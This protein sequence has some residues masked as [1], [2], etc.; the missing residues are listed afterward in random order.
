MS[1]TISFNPFG[2]QTPVGTFLNPTQGYVQGLA[3]DD[4]SSRLWLEGGTLDTG[5]TLTMWGG[6]PL[7]IEINQLTTGSEGL[8]PAVKRST[9][10]ANTLGWSVFN[11]AS[12]MVITPGNSVPQASVGNYIS[13]YR[14]GTNARI[15]A[16][17]DPA[18]VAALTAGEFINAAALYWSV[19]L[20][21]VTLV[22]TGSNFALPTTTV[23]RSVQTN[24]KTVTY[25]SASS[26]TW[27]TGDVAILQI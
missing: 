17:C 8:G 18:L 9:S 10:Q 12:S 6:V 21:W 4:P 7:S 5:E 3:L 25:T 13:F 16:K 14:N 11:Q 2:T 15:A 26:V 22:T 23:L 1:G 27:A 24:S 19:T 20:Y